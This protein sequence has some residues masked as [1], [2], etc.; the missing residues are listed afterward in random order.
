MSLL[1][2]RAVKG[3]SVEATTRCYVLTPSEWLRAINLKLSLE[4]L[5]KVRKKRDT[6]NAS[7]M[8]ARTGKWG[9]E[10]SAFKYLKPKN[11]GASGA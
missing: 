7:E 4:T 6:R 3:Q 10:K 8:E 5:K 1:L 2:P 9:T 11:G